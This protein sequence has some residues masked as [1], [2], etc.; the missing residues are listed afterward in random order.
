[1]YNVVAIARRSY[2]ALAIIATMVSDDMLSPNAGFKRLSPTNIIAGVVCHKPRAWKT[3]A[4]SSALFEFTES[5]PH[6]FKRQIPEQ[7]Q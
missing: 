4:V 2:L 3:V 6:K 7:A 1:L 5:P